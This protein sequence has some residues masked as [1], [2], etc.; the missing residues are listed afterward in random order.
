VDDARSDS[1][2]ESYS[3]LAHPKKPEDLR[4]TDEYL[5][6]L[7]QYVPGYDFRHREWSGYTSSFNK[8]EKL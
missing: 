5:M 2:L 6:L 4:G 7:R 3:H 8:L 1:F